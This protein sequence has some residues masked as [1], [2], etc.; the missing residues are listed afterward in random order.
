[1]SKRAFYPISLPLLKSKNGDIGDEKAVQILKDFAQNSGVG[2][3]EVIDLRREDH[4]IIG[5][6]V[7]TITVAQLGRIPDLDRTIE[8]AC[9]AW[10]GKVCYF[11]A[12]KYYTASTVAANDLLLSESKIEKIATEKGAVAG[13]PFRYMGKICRPLIYPIRESAAQSV[14]CIDATSGE[15]V[16]LFYVYEQKHRFNFN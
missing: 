4:M 10:S 2:K 6:L 11:S 15:A 16:D 3:V 14:L 7:P 5:K 1:M 9:T 8:I 12:G 13:E